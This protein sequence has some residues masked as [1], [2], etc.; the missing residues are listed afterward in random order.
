[1]LVKNLQEMNTAPPI[2]H[3]WH[4][5]FVENRIP[6]DGT[7]L[8]VAPGYEPKI[9]DALSMLPFTGTLFF[10]EPDRK[11]ARDIQKIY[12][13]ILPHA[14]ITAVIKPLEEIRVGIDISVGTDALVASHPFDDMVMASIVG[15]SSFFSK[16]K[17]GGAILSPSM[18]RMYKKITDKDYVSGIRNTVEIWKNFIEKSKPKYFLA[19]QYPSHTLTV[20]KLTK[21]QNSGYTVLGQLK[22]FYRSSLVQQRHKRSFG[23]KGDPKWWIITKEPHKEPLA[24]K[25]LGKEIFVPQPAR[26]LARD[27]YD[28]VYFDKNYFRG[29]ENEVIVKQI[30]NLALVL[31]SR[32]LSASEAII[33]YADRQKDKTDIGLNGNLGSGRAVYYG[34]RFNI[35]GVGKTSLCK[36][37]I[38]S[39]S[40]G[41]LELVGAMRRII[42]SRWINSFT[43][44]APIHAAL[45]AFKE[46]MRVKWSTDPI[47]LSLLIRI[48]NGRLDRPSHVEQYPNIPIDFEKSLSKYAKLDAEYFA[49][50]IMLGAWST[51]NY[52]LDGY[53]IDLE[54]ASFVPYR[55]PYYTS[56]SKYSHNRFGYEGLGFLKILHQ[57]AGVKNIKEKEIE[58]RFYTKRREHLGHCFLLLLGIDD[59]LAS[60]FFFKHKDRVICLSS[61]FER[62]AKKVGTGAANLNL[63]AHIADDEDPTLLD[64]SHFFRNLAKTYKSPNAQKRALEYLLRKHDNPLHFLDETRNFIHAI[65]D[66]LAL[67]EQEKCLGKKEHWEYRLYAMNQNLLTMFELNETLKSLANSYRLGKITPKILGTEINKL[68]ELPIKRLS[69]Y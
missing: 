33:T 36:S 61:Q 29:L 53:M 48:D 15:Q 6:A 12:K 24:F 13:K 9:G 60:E 16:E 11:A 68:C 22:D 4:K 63:Y 2:S 14:T 57:L 21:R 65:F 10:I 28:I 67:M 43:Q 19:S 34:D 47:L 50:R 62:L 44:R 35:L 3:L 17:E 38:Q 66:L 49:Y 25:R 39:H 52:S 1:M 51:S 20:K 42:L 46:T 45:I 27:E 69:K 59:A 31:D 58:S 23:F 7:V 41:K 5:L 40:T 37:T 30:Q 55:G 26:R 32:N 64:I 8:E 56:S 54:S 18:K